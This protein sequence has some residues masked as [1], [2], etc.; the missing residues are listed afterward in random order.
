MWKD[1]NCQNKKGRWIIYN[2]T[3]FC[4]SPRGV[5]K[6]YSGKN[7]LEERAGAAKEGPRRTA[8]GFEMVMTAS[9]ALYRH[10]S[11]R[12]SRLMA[13]IGQAA[14]FFPSVEKFKH[15]CVQTHPTRS[16]T[17]ARTSTANELI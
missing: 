15:A 1:G 7:L 17:Q 16:C 11:A 2:I 5:F 12:L 4:S 14:H 3:T 8:K 13:A 9:R 6:H 10:W